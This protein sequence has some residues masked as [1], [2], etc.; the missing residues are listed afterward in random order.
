MG[1]AAQT[2]A[3]LSIC[4][5]MLHRMMMMMIFLKKSAFVP[6]PA[7]HKKNPNTRLE[8]SNSFP[9]NKKIIKSGNAPMLNSCNG[10]QIP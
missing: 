4:V 6:V 3:Q 1:C 8:D 7:D 2:G 9:R 10:C 5:H